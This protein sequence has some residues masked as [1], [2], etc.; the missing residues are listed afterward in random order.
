M[1]D[2]SSIRPFR[3]NVSQQT[4]DDLHDRLARTRWADGAPTADY[5]VPTGQVKALVE[6]WREGYDWRRWEARVNEYPQYLAQIGGQDI[7]FLHVRSLEMDAFPLILTHGWPGSIVE[8]LRLIDPL[9]DPRSHGGK[10]ADAFHLVIPSLPGFGFSSPLADAGW[11]TARIAQAWA[12]L[13]DRLGYDR[14]GAVGNDAGSM[15]SPELGRI[16]A[17]HVT[18]VHVTQVFSFPSGDPD[19]LAGM[20]D[21]DMAALGKLQWFMDN[22]F[23]FNQLHSQQPQTLAHALADTP[24]GMLAWHLQLMAPD[25]VSGRVLDSDFVLTNATLYWVT[26]SAGSAIRF[27]YE[28]AHAP[29]A[30]PEPSTVPIGLAGFAGDFSGVRRFAERDHA[31]LVQWNLYGQP[32]GHYAAHLATDVVA[33]DIRAFFAKLR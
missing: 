11:G 32:G 30:R 5:G 17:E 14:Y 25:A 24:A 23:S 33:E 28:N 7:H 13:M 18:G 19:E 9:T 21:Q 1:T 6:Y 29:Q 15:V 8:F 31:N 10:P 27:Y 22:K 26:N 16:D 2:T 3:I 4:L 20:T 12:Q